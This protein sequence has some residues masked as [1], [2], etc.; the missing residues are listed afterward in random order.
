MIVEAGKQY[1]TRDGRPVRILCTDMKSAHPVIGV[2]R[3]VRN[4]NEYCET[5]TLDGRCIADQE[6]MR[7]LVEVSPYTDWPIDA[8]VWCNDFRKWVP[9]HFAGVDRDGKPL[10]WNDGY[11][12]HTTALR[13]MWDDMRLASEFT[14]TAE[15]TSK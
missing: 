9:R 2:L 6:S 14:P 12:S 3:F 11:T 8:P 7:D 15:E 1:R 10:A 13:T 4:E 5:W